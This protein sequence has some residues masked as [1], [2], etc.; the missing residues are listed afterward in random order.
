MKCENCWKYDRCSQEDR[1]QAEINDYPCFEA[2]DNE[3]A[4]FERLREAQ[5]GI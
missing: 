5:R 2:P 4:E 3:D 1:E